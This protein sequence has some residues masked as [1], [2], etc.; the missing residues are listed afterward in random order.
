M[1]PS[2]SVPVLLLRVHGV[3]DEEVR[4]SHELDDPLVPV[5]ADVVHVAVDLVVRYQADRPPADVDPVGDHEGGMLDAHDLHP[6]VA[7]LELTLVQV[8]ELHL[9]GH[10]AEG[11]REVDRSHLPREEILD[12]IFI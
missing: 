8:L 9:G 12:G 1:S 10:D 4:V 11:Y 5:G 7:E 3:V 6:H 2:A